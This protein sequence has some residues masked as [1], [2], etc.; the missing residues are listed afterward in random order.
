[1]AMRLRLLSTMLTA[2]G[3]LSVILMVGAL[4]PAVG[5]SIAKLDLPEA[6]PSCSAAPTTER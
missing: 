3:M 4:F 6:W 2:A 5:G 1:M